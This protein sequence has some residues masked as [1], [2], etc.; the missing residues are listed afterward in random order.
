MTTRNKG[1]TSLPLTEATDNRILSESE[2]DAVSGGLIGWGN[3]A[4]VAWYRV[5]EQICD[6]Q[7]PKVCSWPS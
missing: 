3:F 6:A 2:L 4:Q 7:A 1:M 5:Q